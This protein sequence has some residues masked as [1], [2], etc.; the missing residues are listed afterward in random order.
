MAK[1]R[2]G[3]F[4][5]KLTLGVGEEPIGEIAD[6]PVIMAEI[7]PKVILNSLL[8][9][10]TFIKT[11]LFNILTSTSW[12]KLIQNIKTSPNS[13]WLDSFRENSTANKSCNNYIEGQSGIVN[14]YK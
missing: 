8:L 11:Q 5:R 12:I 2:W 1:E 7:S 13:C 3:E 10:E 9:A 14:Y 6:A 4:L